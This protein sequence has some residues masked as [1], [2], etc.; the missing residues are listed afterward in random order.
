M[1]NTGLISQ[2]FLFL[3]YFFFIFSPRL[4][5]NKN[6]LND[7][8]IFQIQLVRLEMSFLLE[9]KALETNI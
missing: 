2:D 8:G 7:S 5:I 6:S 1:L 3:F 9:Q 4:F